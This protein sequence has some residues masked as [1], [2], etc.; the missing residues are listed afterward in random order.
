MIFKRS[1]VRLLRHTVTPGIKVGRY[2]NGL[3]AV[4]AWDQLAHLLVVERQ[5]YGA[6]ENFVAGIY[7]SFQG[8]KVMLWPKGDCQWREST[9]YELYTMGECLD[10]LFALWLVLSDRAG[11]IKEGE[12]LPHMLVALPELHD[13]VDHHGPESRQ[14]AHDLGRLLTHGREGRMH[15]L[16]N[17]RQGYI[18]PAYLPQETRRQLLVLGKTTDAVTQQLELPQAFN[19]PHAHLGD[20][21]GGFWPLEVCRK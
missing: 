6:G 11:R 10:E 4:W 5:E 20:L 13:A 12:D 1:R 2:E 8:R 15:V 21:E 14:F 17:I 16:A 19:R 7:R 3:D 18:Y 9:D